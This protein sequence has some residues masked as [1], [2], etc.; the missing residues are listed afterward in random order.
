MEKIGSG[1][2][3]RISVDKVKNRIYF[4]FF[5]DVMSPAGVADLPND[6]KSA[7]KLTSPGFTGLADFTEVKLLGLPDVTQQTQA[8]LAA[9]GI[10]K[11]AS[12]WNRES[13]AKFV[14]DSSAHK[15]DMYEQ[16]RE[17]F[18]STSEAEAWLNE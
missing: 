14:V 8:A 7:L 12:V 5:G 13:F 15:V 2:N 17:V 9:G 11:V 6:L 4:W 10:R 1:T 18:F 3:Y 16:R